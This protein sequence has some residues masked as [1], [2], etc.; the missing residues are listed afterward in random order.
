MGTCGQLETNPR[1]FSS[2]GVLYRF[3]VLTLCAQFAFS[4]LAMK[5]VLLP[6][7]L[8]LW[9]ISKTQFGMLMSVYGI[10]HNVLYVALSWVQDRYSSRVL[11][12]INMVM[13]G[14]T[15]FFLGVAT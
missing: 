6:Q 7:M 1:L 15:T 2:R 10:T 12:P 13:G 9:E 11:I 5:G 14:V 8:T 4:V 3:I